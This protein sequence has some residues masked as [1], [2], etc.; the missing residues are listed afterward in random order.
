MTFIKP[1]ISVILIVYNRNQYIEEALDSL[2]NQDLNKELYEVILVTNLNLH[3]NKTFL[4]KL[5]VINSNIKS[6]WGKYFQGLDNAS[7]EVISFLEDDD[8]FDKSKLSY[9]YEYFKKYN[10]LIYYKNNTLN[11]IDSNKIILNNYPKNT[12]KIFKNTK[13]LNYKKIIKMNH[14]YRLGFNTSSITIKRIILEKYKDYV[15][16]D[17][18]IIFSFDSFLF[19]LA[20]EDGL[21]IIYD[22]RYL[23]YK[24]ISNK[25]VSD[26]VNSSLLYSYISNSYFYYALIIGKFKNKEVQKVLQ[27][28]ILVSKN[29]LYLNMQ[30]NLSSK[31]MVLLFYNIFT[32]YFSLFILGLFLRTFLKYYL[33]KSFKYIDR[34][35]KK[36]YEIIKIKVF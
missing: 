28:D 1:Y 13:L 36:I 3:L 6:A 31:D 12:I 21:D 32:P 2:E 33:P 25:N 20:L 34:I 35:Y 29:Q 14:D 4:M 19:Y 23:T 8:L 26:E 24:R 16:S 5:K 9:L 18:N 17:I 11:F 7:G 22:G 30:I 10:K 27:R 15:P